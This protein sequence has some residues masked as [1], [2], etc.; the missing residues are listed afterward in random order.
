MSQSESTEAGQAKEVQ[1][2]DEIDELLMRAILSALAAGDLLVNEREGDLQVGSKGAPT[3]VVTIMD[4]K[5]ESLLVDH[6]LTGREDDG[7]L[8]EEGASRAGTS[9]VRWIVD[10]IDGTVNYMYR[11][12]EWAVSIAAELNGEIVAGVVHAPA[13]GETYVA[14]KGK[15]AA[16]H[17][18]GVQR[19]LTVNPA[20]TMDRALVATGFGYDVQRRKAQARVAAE[21][22]PQVRDIRRAGSASV[23][24]C[25]LAAGR[26]D[27]FY[28]RGLNTWDH[29]A[30]GLIAQE[31]GATIGGLNGEAP[32][33]SFYLAAPEPLFSDLSEL[34]TRLNAASD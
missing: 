24:I 10:P 9:G 34:L 3:D 4:R 22:I 11:L 20:P 5:A 12:P 7:I 31:A 29:A 1:E 33:E 30:A 27:A 25:S 32:G 15:G 26:V 19:K 8:G 18:Q 6:L 16:L 13:L 23:D 21:V 2:R 28:E 17:K 14:G